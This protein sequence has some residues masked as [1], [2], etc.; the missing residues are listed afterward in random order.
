[1]TH[2][3]GLHLLPGRC[4]EGFAPVQHP[5]FC[6]C[7]AFGG[8][9]W[10]VFVRVLKSVKRPDGTIHPGDV[11]PLI[12]GRIEHKH[13]GQLYRRAVGEKILEFTGR[14]EPSNDTVGRNTDKLDRIYILR[15][16]VPA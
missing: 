2:P 15:E 10:Q 14:R 11:R 13:I 4:S 7:P 1:M 3:L 6:L 8:T 12:R 5:R 16:R 9:E